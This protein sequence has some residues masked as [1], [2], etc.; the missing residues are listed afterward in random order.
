MIAGAEGEGFAFASDE[1][2]S[3]GA[4]GEL[5]R[6]ALDGTRTELARLPGAID[7]AHAAG[8][9][10]SAVV[11][12]RTLCRIELVSGG[13]GCVQLPKPGTAIRTDGAG[14]TWVIAGGALLRW[15]GTGPPIPELPSITF[16]A[17]Y[18]TGRETIAVG[19]E[20][21]VVV[22]RRPLAPVAIPPTQ[23][24]SGATDERIVGVSPD[25]ETLM[26][27]IRT[28]IWYDVPLPPPRP[29]LQGRAYSDGAT[30]VAIRPTS[31]RGE[32]H[33]APYLFELP[34]AAR[35]GRAPRVAGDRD[36]RDPGRRHRCRRVAVARASVAAGLRRDQLAG[37]QLL[38][39]L[40]RRGSRCTRR[41]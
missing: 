9:V 1:V 3:L 35:A 17:L 11:A 15:S 29:G 20:G 4:E 36:Q 33:E 14:T 22:S 24:I 26:I 13:F 2:L 27:D 34:R 23:L 25:G 30:V 41:R 32:A 5:A 40:A 16:Q 37:D 38:V 18:A 12:E 28:G 31:R 7:L 6:V 39:G 21:V 19:A 10:L 8:K